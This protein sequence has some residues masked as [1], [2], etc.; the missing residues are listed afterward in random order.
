MFIHHVFFWLKEALSEQDI[1]AFEKGV[2]SLLQIEHIKTG[3]VGK[4]A[5]TNRPIIDTSYTYSLLL[6]FEDQAA[7]DRYQPHPVHE[8]FIQDCAHLWSRVLIYDSESIKEV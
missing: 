6:V 1:K 7:H 3:D 2:S 8:K 5:S 4:P